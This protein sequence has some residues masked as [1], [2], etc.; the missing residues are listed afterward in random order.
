MNKKV[1][2]SFAW[3]QTLPKP[4]WG[5]PVSCRATGTLWHA[6]CTQACVAAAVGAVL[7]TLA[8]FEVLHQCDY[9]LKSVLRLYGWYPHHHK[10]GGTVHAPQSPCIRLLA[11]PAPTGLVPYMY[12]CAALCGVLAH[13][14]RC[15]KCT[16]SSLWIML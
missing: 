2:T 1:H 3:I 5:T 11:C 9:E 13:C 8:S 10:S 16:S 7:L 6:V 12:V 4:P 14:L 15:L